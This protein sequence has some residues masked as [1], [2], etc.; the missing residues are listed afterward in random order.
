MHN[1]HIGAVWDLAN[2]QLEQCS[3]ARACPGCSIYLYRKITSRNFGFC[4]PSTRQ[5]NINHRNLPLL[6][7][8]VRTDSNSMGHLRVLE[9]K[10]SIYGVG[11][12]AE[13]SI[14]T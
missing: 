7:V 8:G 9:A 12:F 13:N 4:I 3:G 5:V 10:C 6:C 11:I 14:Y 1:T 2:S